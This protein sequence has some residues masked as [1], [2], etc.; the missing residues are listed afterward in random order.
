MDAERNFEKHRL[1][2]SPRNS[3]EKFVVR[4]IEAKAKDQGPQS[5]DRGHSHQ[6]QGQ[7]FQG[8]G[9]CQR[10]E[11]CPQGQGMSWKTTSLTFINN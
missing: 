1:Y 7:C 2:A 11:F 6:V 10:R 8:Q 3:P 9:Q 5:Q 4:T